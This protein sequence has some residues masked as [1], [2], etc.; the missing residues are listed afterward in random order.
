MKRLKKL[1]RQNKEKFAFQTV[2]IQLSTAEKDIRLVIGSTGVRMVLKTHDEIYV[3]SAI[4]IY[5]YFSFIF[6]YRFI[7]GNKWCPW[8]IGKIFTKYQQGNLIFK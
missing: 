4:R 8:N 7:K 1:S 2:V 6:S 3:W 5:N